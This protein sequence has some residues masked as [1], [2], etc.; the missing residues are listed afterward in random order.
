MNFVATRLL[1]EMKIWIELVQFIVPASG[2]F[3]FLLLLLIKVDVYFLR[4]DFIGTLNIDR[5]ER[6]VKIV[7]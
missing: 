7:L 4:I 2:I 1:S 3:S 6:L 5:I